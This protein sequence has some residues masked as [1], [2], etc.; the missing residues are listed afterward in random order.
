ML[1]NHLL[2]TLSERISA[3]LRRRLV[4][5]DFVQGAVLA[6]PDA[7]I[8]RLLFP[9]SGLISIVVELDGGDQIEAGL[10]G[11]RGAHGGAAIRGAEQ[12]LSTAVSQL[13]G[14]AWS[15]RVADA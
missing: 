1:D 10:G 3:D 4:P 7:P 11:R 5:L 12:H 2:E 9:R 15:M 8:E 14:R 6:E 13:A